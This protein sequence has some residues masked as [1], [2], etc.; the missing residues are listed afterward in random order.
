MK[1]TLS[2]LL[3]LLLAFTWA[4]SPQRSVIVSYPD[5]TPDSVLD[6]AKSAVKQ[7]GGMIIHEYSTCSVVHLKI[8]IEN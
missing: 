2:L 3:T 1:L 7:A 5:D 4:T 8:D 6:E